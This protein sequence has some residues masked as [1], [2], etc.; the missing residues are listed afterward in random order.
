[1]TTLEAGT[2]KARAHNPKQLQVARQPRKDFIPN[3]ESSESLTALATSIG[4][5]EESIREKGP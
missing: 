1:M 2:H 3:D 4:F 5:D